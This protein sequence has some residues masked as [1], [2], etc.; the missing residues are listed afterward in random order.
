M[1]C[2]WLFLNGDGTKTEATLKEDKV[3]N[4]GDGKSHRSVGYVV[5]YVVIGR[6]TSPNPFVIATEQANA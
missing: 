1:H 2:D 4:P 5:R 6:T 3:P